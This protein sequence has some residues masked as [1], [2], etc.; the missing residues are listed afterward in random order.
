MSVAKTSGGAL[1]ISSN[2]TSFPVIT[3][4]DSA[5]GCHLNSPGVSVHT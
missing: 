2:R 1:S 3:A 5:P 4:I